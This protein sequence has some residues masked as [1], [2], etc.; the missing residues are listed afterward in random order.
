M[1]RN[2]FATIFKKLFFY[3]TGKIRVKFDKMVT[4][5]DQ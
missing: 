2:Q 1:G 3:E 5:S 4:N